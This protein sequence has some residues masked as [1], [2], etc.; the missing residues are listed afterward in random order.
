MSILLVNRAGTENCR[1][2]TTSGWL[3][4]RGFAK[5][6]WTNL[7]ICRIAEECPHLL[8]QIENRGEFYFEKSVK[9]WPPL[10]SCTKYAH[11]QINSVSPPLR[12][13]QSQNYSWAVF[14]YPIQKPLLCHSENFYCVF[15]V[16]LLSAIMGFVAFCDKHSRCGLKYFD[17]S[18]RA[19]YQYE[20]KKK[21]D[22]FTLSRL[23]ILIV[24]LHTS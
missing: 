7:K 9:S 3:V 20:I 23:W 5:S 2:L 21:Q 13:I 18:H 12:I 6:S 16:I 15:I 19:A 24:L 4:C 1:M 11:K 17:Q 14:L 8:S 10:Y 22:S